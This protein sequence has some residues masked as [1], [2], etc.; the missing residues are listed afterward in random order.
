[1]IALSALTENFLRLVNVLR[2][3]LMMVCA[4]TIAGYFYPSAEVFEVSVRTITLCS[5]LLALL[6][7][8]LFTTQRIL[9][10]A[11]GIPLGAER[12]FDPI[13]SGLL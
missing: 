12:H 11:K 4:F 5:G 8:L 7:L 13:N 3:V 1:M 9:K 2:V 6:V 10:F